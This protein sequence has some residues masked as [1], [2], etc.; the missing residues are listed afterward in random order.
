MIAVKIFVT[1]GSNA[2]AEGALDGTI[3]AFQGRPCTPFD[4]FRRW[5]ALPAESWPDYQM[6]YRSAWLA[7]IARRRGEVLA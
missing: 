1:D 5:N 2:A 4:R 7:I 3:D 6:A